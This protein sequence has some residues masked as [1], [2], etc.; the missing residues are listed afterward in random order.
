MNLLKLYQGDVD[1]AS[2]RFNHALSMQADYLPALLN[3]AEVKRQQRDF[4]EAERLYRKA[5]KKV[6]LDKQLLLTQARFYL[7]SGN[8]SK[9]LQ[10]AQQAWELNPQDLAA[11]FMT[12]RVHL[13]MGDPSAAQ[14]IAEQLASPSP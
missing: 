6:P 14:R 4:D 11:G 1:A 8:N 13:T 12:M 10:T 5:S 9:A 3:L 7:Y 2:E